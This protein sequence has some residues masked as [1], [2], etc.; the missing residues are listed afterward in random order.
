MT[1]KKLIK[2]KSQQTMKQ[3]GLLLIK[4]LTKPIKFYQ[5]WVASTFTQGSTSK[6]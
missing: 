2:M 3:F 6:F 5:L 4:T 1:K